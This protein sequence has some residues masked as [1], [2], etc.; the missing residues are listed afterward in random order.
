MA[1]AADLYAEARVGLRDTARW[2][3]TSL[4]ALGAALAGG[5]SFGILPVLGEDQLL[6]G[7]AVGGSVLFCILVAIIL[8]Q[9]ILFPRAFAVDELKRPDVQRLLQPHL[10][11]L[12]PIGVATLDDLANEIA[13]SATPQDRRNTLRAAQTK[14]TSFAAF[15]DLDRKVRRTNW[16]ILVLFVVACAGIGYL[17][18]LKGIAEA[19]KQ[20]PEEKAVQFS[21]AAGWVKLAEDLSRSCPGAG[22]FSATGKPDTPFV[23]WWTITLTAPAPCAGIMVS[24]PNATVT[25]GP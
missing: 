18:Y 14:I 16:G 5:L 2:Y 23:G 8:M 9:N 20:Q 17:A 22:P 12:L 15:L 19:E 6:T 10:R 7:L 11:E 4:A 24:V 25:T 3:T 13:N 1:E 21:P